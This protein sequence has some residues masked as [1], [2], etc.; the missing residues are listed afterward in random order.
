M[1]FLLY[2]YVSLARWSP[3]QHPTLKWPSDLQDQR[4][5]CVVASGFTCAAATRDGG[6]CFSLA[7]QEK[8]PNKEKPKTKL[9]TVLATEGKSWR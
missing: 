9:N 6:Y 7:T 1:T 5:P 2:R 4:P 8:P 3:V